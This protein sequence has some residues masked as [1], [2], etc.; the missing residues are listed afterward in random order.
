MERGWIARR[1]AACVEVV[2]LQPFGDIRGH[3]LS[4]WAIGQAQS[5]VSMLLVACG[6]ASTRN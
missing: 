5:A 2:E 1:I 6:A 4:P 3:V